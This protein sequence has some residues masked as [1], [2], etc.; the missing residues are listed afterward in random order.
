MVGVEYNKA[1]LFL[2]QIGPTLQESS[3]LSQI[4]M[5]S[6]LGGC[7]GKLRSRALTKCPW[8]Q[9]VAFGWGARFPQSLYSVL[10]SCS[11]AGMSQ[12][13]VPTPPWGQLKMGA[14]R[15]VSKAT[16]PMVG[17]GA[18]VDDLEVITSLEAWCMHY[19]LSGWDT[20]ICNP[21]CTEMHTMLFEMYACLVAH[22]SIFFV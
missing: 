5:K 10:A 7:F 19:V 16:R 21:L 2:H 14:L 20:S 15:I 17:F 6:C 13:G 4:S 9:K 22:V 18:M 11:G 8:M 3:Q 1:M 12:V